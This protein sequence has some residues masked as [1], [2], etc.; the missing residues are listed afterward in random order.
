MYEYCPEIVRGIG[1]RACDAGNDPNNS[2]SSVVQSFRI[3]GTM[4]RP[5]GE[6]RDC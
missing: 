4:G 1:E 5:S 3:E 6:A 2:N